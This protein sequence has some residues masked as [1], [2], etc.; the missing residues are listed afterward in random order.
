M[1]TTTIA[2]TTEATTTEKAAKAPTSTEWILWE[3]NFGKRVKT[4]LQWKESTAEVCHFFH[5]SDQPSFKCD[6]H[7]LP[8]PSKSFFLKEDHQHGHGHGH[9][10]HSGNSH[11]SNDDDHH[12]KHKDQPHVAGKTHKEYSLFKKGI[13]P[14]WE[15]PANVGGGCWYV[16]QY[17]PAKFLDHYWQ[18]L[19]KCVVDELVDVT[20]I[21]GIRIDDKSK[22]KHPVYKIEVWFANCNQKIRNQIRDELVKHM[23][24]DQPNGK[25]NPIKFHWRNFEIPSDHE[26]EDESQQDTVNSSSVAS[27][28]EAPASSPTPAAAATA[29]AAVT[30][31]H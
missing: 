11:D 26:H 23:K 3:H 25:V 17:F 10:H 9:G 30:V 18:N 12:H 13:F 29:P 31:G 14:D 28:T 24:Q 8:L 6:L 4:D 22:F 2:A 1:T 27:S 16:R 19:V 5:L 15:D 21:N 20:Y 7:H